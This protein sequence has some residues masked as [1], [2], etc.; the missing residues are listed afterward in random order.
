[1]FPLESSILGGTSLTLT[2]T[3]FSTITTDNVVSVGTTACTAT[4]SNSSAIVCTLAS[5]AVT[6]A[7]NN[8]GVD[9]GKM[10]F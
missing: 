5:P 3:D 2:G 8:T 6:H 7:V 4:S 1:M 9:P 10:L